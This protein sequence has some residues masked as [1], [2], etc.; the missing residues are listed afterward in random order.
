MTHKATIY[1]RHAAERL[2]ERGI[3]RWEVQAILHRGIYQQEFSEGEPRHSKRL[4]L[5]E[6]HGEREIMVVYIERA[7]ERVI[8]TVEFTDERS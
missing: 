3:T 5:P 8:V 4:V 6:R 1:S 2:K 7:T